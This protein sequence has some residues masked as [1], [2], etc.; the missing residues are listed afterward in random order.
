[1]WSGFEVI[2]DAPGMSLGVCYRWDLNLF[3]LIDFSQ[4]LSGGWLWFSIPLGV[5]AS[6]GVVLLSAAKNPGQAVKAQ[7]GFAVVTTTPSVGL[8]GR[9]RSTACKW[10]GMRA[11]SVFGISLS[12]PA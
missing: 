6:S 8:L 5:I 9:C 3:T 2:G 11:S 12:A 10:L 7:P 4:L 1:M